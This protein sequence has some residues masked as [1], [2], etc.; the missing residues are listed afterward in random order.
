MNT[1]TI[2]G[3]PAEWMMRTVKKNPEGL[4]LLA[5]GCALLLR[6]GGCS[7]ASNHQRYA[8][9]ADATKSYGSSGRDWDMPE[10]ASRA[11]DTARE[12]ASSARPAVSDTAGRYASTA[13]H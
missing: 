10:Q 6:S 4:L 9:R 8:S 2:S 5:A 1:S 3:D 12:Y 7:R 13:S 11:V